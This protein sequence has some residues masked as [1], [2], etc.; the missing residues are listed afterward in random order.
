[1]SA[2]SS[3]SEEA[4]RAHNVVDHSRQAPGLERLVRGAEPAAVDLARVLADLVRQVAAEAL[5][6]RVA[7]Q[8]AVL[9]VL[10]VGGRGAHGTLG[11]A[12]KRWTYVTM[13][14]G[15]VGGAWRYMLLRQPRGRRLARLG[16]RSGGS[17]RP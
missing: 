16:V 14:G 13:S 4:S 1:M 2:T 3:S 5:L 17:R 10:L 15:G 7:C 6:V 11:Q 12:S 9:L 8:P